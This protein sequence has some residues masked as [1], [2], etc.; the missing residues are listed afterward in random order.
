MALWIDKWSVMF[1]F[2]SKIDRFWHEKL[3]S[4][5]NVLKCIKYHRITSRLLALFLYCMICLILSINVLLINVF[6]LKILNF[7]VILQ[8]YLSA[9]NS[10]DD[11]CWPE[12]DEASIYKPDWL[13]HN[14]MSN[15]SANFRF[16][17]ETWH[18]PF[19]QLIKVT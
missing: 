19:K 6:N 2:Y 8:Q 12:V 5:E 13:T 16:C 10:W 3:L 9:K 17:A 14:R 1:S 7:T 4:C 18:S 15:Q 11:L